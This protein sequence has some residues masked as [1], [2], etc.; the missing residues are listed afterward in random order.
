M[1]QKLVD[2]VCAASLSVLG[3][4]SPSNARSEVVSSL[5]GHSVVSF[6]EKRDDNLWVRY[7]DVSEPYVR[8][9]HTRHPEIVIPLKVYTFKV[10]CFLDGMPLKQGLSLMEYED[11]LAVVLALT[12]DAQSLTRMYAPCGKHSVFVRVQGKEG[13]AV[14]ELKVCVEENQ[15]R[16]NRLNKQY[17]NK[18]NHDVK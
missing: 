10:H 2:L 14:R 5:E 11:G 6:S 17:Y 9:D 15:Y 4:A 3:C 13:Y 8:F 1:N 16:Y 12:A 7:V 18:K